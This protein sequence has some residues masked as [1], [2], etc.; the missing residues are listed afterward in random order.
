MLLEAQCLCVLITH[1][2]ISAQIRHSWN[3]WPENWLLSPAQWRD[4]MGLLWIWR[5]WCSRRALDARFIWCRRGQSW[6]TFEQQL[7]TQASRLA[8]G[9][10]IKFV[11]VTDFFVNKLQLPT[12]VRL[13]ALPPH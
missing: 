9:T 12:K 10:V 11:E 4:A 8:S 5:A 6:S 2:S 7:Y 3:N 13:P 1:G